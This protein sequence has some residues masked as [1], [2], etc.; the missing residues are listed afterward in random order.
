M[1]KLCDQFLEHAQLRYGGRGSDQAGLFCYD[2]G[3][4]YKWIYATTV[5]LVSRP[6]E[7]G[8]ACILRLFP[9]YN[10]APGTFLNF[11]GWKVS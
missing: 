7:A 3:S 4:I 9:A 8:V 10:A 5:A 6:R 2:E 1:E 11:C